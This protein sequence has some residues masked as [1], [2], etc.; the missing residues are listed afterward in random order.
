[1]TISCVIAQEGIGIVF[2]T[3]AD[4]GEQ[5]VVEDIEFFNNIVH[6]SGSAIT[7]YGGQGEGG[8]RMIIRNNLIYNIDSKKYDGRGFFIL[9]SEWD[10]LIV[11]NNT[12]IHD[13]SI[14]IAYGKPITGLSFKNNI[15]FQNE[16]G[17]FGDGIGIGKVAI[18][19]YFPKGLFFNNIIVGGSSEE[20]GR[21]NF[22][23]VSIRQIG[24]EDVR[25][26]NYQLSSSNPYLRKSL[27]SKQIGASLNPNDIG[28][29]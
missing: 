7:V 18:N 13:G 11:E 10:G 28:G 23:P 4:S 29:K 9:T 12:V 20:Y 16:Y 26:N 2:M 5:A 24:F 25:N 3:G 15:V 8:R 27:N 6:S 21:E 19:K 17:V 14:F 22:Y 1:M